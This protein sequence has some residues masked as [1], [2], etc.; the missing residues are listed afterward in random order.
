MAATRIFR[1]FGI[2]GRFRM[3]EVAFRAMAKY[4]NFTDREVQQVIYNGAK[5]M[6]R[7][8]YPLVEG[9]NRITF[10]PRPRDTME[11]ECHAFG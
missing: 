2:F 10:S 1:I 4:Y 8:P 11:A 6:P 5:D 9:I 7:K 3:K